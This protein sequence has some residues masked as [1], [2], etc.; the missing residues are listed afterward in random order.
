MSASYERERKTAEEIALDAGEKIREFFNKQDGWVK[1]KSANNP[2]TQADLEANAIIQSSLRKAFPGDGWCSEETDRA[3]HD[4]EKERIWIVDPLDG[5]IEFTMKIPEFAVSIGLCVS[6]RPVMG[7]IYNPIKGELFSGSLEEGVYLN[8]VSSGLSGSARLETARILVSGTESK[9]GQVDFLK[10]KVRL[11]P[12]GGTAYKLALVSA[13]I[14]DG[15]VS[16]KPKNNWDFA[17]GVALAKASGA[18]T[19]D[20]DGSDLEEL[21]RKVSGLCIGQRPWHSELFTLLRSNIPNE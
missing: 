19:C 15:Y 9:R 14:Y 7:V 11:F 12:L 4:M 13:G 3:S 21:P 10:D 6:G 18:E 1:E 17:A 16:V 2:L 8:G 20:L 5:T